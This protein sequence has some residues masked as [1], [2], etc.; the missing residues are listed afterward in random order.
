MRTRSESCR[1]ASAKWL[2]IPDRNAAPKLTN[3]ATTATATIAHTRPASISPP[4]SAGSRAR[5]SSAIAM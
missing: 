1:S 2:T 4:D 3:S 5:A